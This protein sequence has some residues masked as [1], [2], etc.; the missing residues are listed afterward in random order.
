MARKIGEI[1][2]YNDEWYQCLKSNGTCVD[3]AGFEKYGLKRGLELIKN[4]D[5][6]EEN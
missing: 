2:K 5:Y 3:C 4:K 6:E 1:F